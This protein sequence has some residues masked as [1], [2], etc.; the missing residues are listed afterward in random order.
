[1]STTI[2][3]ICVLLLVIFVAIAGG[4]VFLLNLDV[5]RSFMYPRRRVW[6]LI[7][8]TTDTIDEEFTEK[9]Q[10]P[11]HYALVRMD[12]SKPSTHTVW[13]E[14]S[15][16]VG[17]NNSAYSQAITWAFSHDFDCEFVVCGK[18]KDPHMI[19]QWLR[20]RKASRIFGTTGDDNCVVMSRDV[21]IGI[22]NAGFETV[23]Q[24]NSQKIF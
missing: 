3:V 1:M 20:G 10:V 13:E 19:Q 14:P 11:E 16:V 15:L 21:A 8:S 23:E 4:L 7:D 9:V 18:P 2:L 5:D 6:Y 24:E 17:K 12:I 22:A